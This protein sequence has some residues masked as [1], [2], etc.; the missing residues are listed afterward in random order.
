MEI[1][2]SQELDPGS[3]LRDES[4][5]VSQSLLAHDDPIQT[6][7]M[8]SGGL[9]PKSERI[10][11]KI[12]D[13]KGVKEFAYK[14]EVGRCK[15]FFN[16]LGGIKRHI[17]SK[18]PDKVGYVQEMEETLSKIIETAVNSTLIAD[19]DVEDDGLG[20]I[21]LSL[22]QLCSHSEGQGWRRQRMM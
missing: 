12:E 21:M 4:L 8:A 3:Q 22:S 9:R 10:G 1:L 5:D 15:N 7:M 19:A 20:L 6:Q 14:C 11:V 17:H 2:E 16:T 13:P 18:H